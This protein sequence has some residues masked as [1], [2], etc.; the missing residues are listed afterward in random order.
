MKKHKT[1]YDRGFKLLATDR[2]F[3]FKSGLTAKLDG[4]QGDFDQQIINEIVLWKVSRYAQID[5]DTLELINML[6]NDSRRL[7]IEKTKIILKALLKTKGIQLPMASAILR[8]K[9]KNIYQIIDQRVYRVLY[10][11]K[12]LKLKKH[13]SEKNLNEQIEIYLKYLKDLSKACRSLKIP[14]EASDRILFMVDRRINKDISL[15]NY[16]TKNGKEM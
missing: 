5:S 6:N 1:V 10:K 14:F 16:S 4:I 15:D 7:D 12:K 9:N 3:D 11:G 8:F 13:T 2:N